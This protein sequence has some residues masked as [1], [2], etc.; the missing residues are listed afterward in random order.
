MEI[1]QGEGV[2]RALDTTPKSGDSIN[3]MLQSTRRGGTVVLAGIKG[4]DKV[5]I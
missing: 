1:T 2:H 5:P 4:G 3:Q